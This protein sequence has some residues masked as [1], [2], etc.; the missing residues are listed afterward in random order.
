MIL[1]NGICSDES[2]TGTLSLTIEHCKYSVTTY[3]NYL[4]CAIDILCLL[5]H[6]L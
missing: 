4:D 1:Y 2:T 5:L 6:V 3:M